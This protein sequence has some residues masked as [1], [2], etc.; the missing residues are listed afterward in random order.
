M[1][2][3]IKDDNLNE[4]LPILENLIL[5]VDAI[6]LPSKCNLR[7]IQ[8][9]P[10]TVAWVIESKLRKAWSWEIAIEK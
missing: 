6:K 1:V 5:E 8:M 9:G 2:A 4:K 3:E 10:A 7:Y